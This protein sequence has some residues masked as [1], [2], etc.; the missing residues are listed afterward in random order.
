MTLNGIHYLH[1]K[2]NDIVL[3]IAATANVNAALLMSFLHKAV[4]VFKAYFK[5]EFDEN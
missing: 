3:V 1:T 2:Q 5:G 4:E